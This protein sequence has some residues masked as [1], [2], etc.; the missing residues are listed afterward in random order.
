MRLR[1]YF[2]LSSGRAYCPLLQRPLCA[3]KTLGLG[4]RSGSD[5][6]FSLQT[7]PYAKC[8]NGWNRMRTKVQ[9]RA[10]KSIF[11]VEGRS[12]KSMFQFC[13]L[14]RCLRHSE[15]TLIYL[16]TPTVRNLQTTIREKGVRRIPEMG[17]VRSVHAR[18]HLP[19]RKGIQSW[20]AEPQLPKYYP[21]IL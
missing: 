5:T 12:S 6:R 17:E 4:G 20:G 14:Y 10:V 8:K 16:E 2:W 3:L 18:P 7:R 1:S 19:D 21:S 13:I 11:F 9:C 15:T